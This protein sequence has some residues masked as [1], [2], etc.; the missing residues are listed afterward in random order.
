MTGIQ[1]IEKFNFVC[2][3]KKGF[4]DS[5]SPPPSAFLVPFWSN[6]PL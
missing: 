2:F 6:F 3:Y 1:V 5:G 4:S